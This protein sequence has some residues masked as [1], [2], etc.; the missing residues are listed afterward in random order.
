MK[1]INQIK[2]WMLFNQNTSAT[3]YCAPLLLGLTSAVNAYA[4]APV[5]T[6]SSSSHQLQPS[7]AHYHEFINSEFSNNKFTSLPNQTSTIREDATSAPQI[8]TVNADVVDDASLEAW[9]NEIGWQ[10]LL[11]I[12]SM[13]GAYAVSDIQDERFFLTSLHDGLIS[14]KDEMTALLTAIH[15]NQT[16]L[17]CRFPARSAWLIQKLG[18]NM[19]ICDDFERWQLADSTQ[20]SVIFAEEHP[21]NIGSSFA[22]VL[23]RADNQKSL[24]TAND[25]DAWAINYTVARNE[26]DSEAVAAIKSMTGKYDGIMQIMP[27]DKKNTDYRV[28]DERDLW[29]YALDLTPEQ[30]TQIMRHIYETR[31]I[32]RPY[33]FTHDNC[34]TEIVRLVDLVR[35]DLSLAKDLGRITTPN[36]II[37]HLNRAGMLQSSVFKPSNASVRTAALSDVNAD[38]FVNQNN[39][40]YSSPTHRL[41]V[42]VGQRHDESY[43]G[44]A[45][46]SAYQDVLDRQVGTR[47]YLDLT[48][49]S[50]D[51]RIRDD[52]IGLHEAIIFSTRSYN[53]VNTQKT[54]GKMATG[55][56]LAVYEVVDASDNHN[57]DHHVLHVSK[58]W[59]KSYV[60]GKTN[61]AGQMPNGLCYGFVA[62]MGQVGHINKGYRV[63][64]GLNVGCLYHIN[65]DWRVEGLLSTPLWY[66]HDVAGA[67]QSNPKDYYISPSMSLAMQYDLTPNHAIRLSA[68]HERVNQNHHNSVNVAYLHYFD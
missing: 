26:S 30:V 14:P 35:T 43:V 50:A 16:E 66:H 28:T 13:H 38:D 47:Q 15:Q 60:F 22:H 2:S 65:D 37:R 61:G 44:L 25:E 32:I 12:K 21:S 20:L 4:N 48:M 31:D 54:Y 45:I 10:R 39:A 52:D 27:F 18:Q 8:G 3:F 53:P 36:E 64:A 41:G 7:F 56:H 29:Q 23:M 24:M 57:D 51:V 11:L 40:I 67:P 58:E 6:A 17:M 34:A 9:S 63:G 19:L 55:H 62:A 68:E 49:L 46:R 59:G 33:Y 5:D 1:K 42:S